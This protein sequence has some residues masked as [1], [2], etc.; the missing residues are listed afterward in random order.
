[1]F[2]I[3]HD[4]LVD[5]DANRQR[6]RQQS[7]TVQVDPSR[8]IRPN[9]VSTEVGIEIITISVLRQVCRTA[10]D[11]PVRITASINVVWMLLN[12]CCV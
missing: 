8:F 2:S 9:V 11:Q 3:T 4:A 7:R 10:A 6:Q 12:D 5:Q 1:M